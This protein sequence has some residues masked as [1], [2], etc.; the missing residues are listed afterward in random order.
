MDG[1]LKVT[2]WTVSIVAAALL[3]ASGMYAHDHAAT[4]A[5]RGTPAGLYRQ[6]P[7]IFA[8]LLA[9][10]ALDSPVVVVIVT[11]AANSCLYYLALTLLYRGYSRFRRPA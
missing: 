3:S 8:G 1:K 11:V 6:M 2:R 9:G 5:V 4:A 7:G 10:F